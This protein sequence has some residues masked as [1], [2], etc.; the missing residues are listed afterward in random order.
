[1]F[2]SE[3]RDLDGA[4]ILHDQHNSEAGSDFPS[5]GPDAAKIVGNGAGSDVVILGSSAQ[6]QVTY[7]AADEPGLVSLSAE[8]PY[9]S[10]RELF[11]VQVPC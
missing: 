7:A 8:A 1:M 10:S 11:R 2:A 3:G 4:A 5:S 9:Y 6:K